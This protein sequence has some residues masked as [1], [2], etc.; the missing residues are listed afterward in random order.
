MAN[1]THYVV[2]AFVRDEQGEL[3]AEA[4]TQLPG[5]SLAISR[6]KSL[7]STKAG[8]IAFSRTGDP[9]LGD[10][11]VILFKAGEVPEDVFDQQ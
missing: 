8:A 4:P 7:A 6:A 9:A 11:K 5:A 10:F 1:L 2:M 3:V